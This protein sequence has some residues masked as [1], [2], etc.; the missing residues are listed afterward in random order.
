MPFYNP[1]SDKY[2]Q[3]YFMNNNRF[4]KNFFVKKQLKELKE[5]KKN[6]PIATKIYLEPLDIKKGEQLVENINK[7]K[8]KKRRPL[9]INYS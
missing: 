5:I 8:K 3:P 1:V 4:N 9:S 7:K 6:S 2:L